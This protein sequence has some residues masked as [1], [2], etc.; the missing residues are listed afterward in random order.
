MTDEEFFL[1]K[2]VPSIFSEDIDENTT[3]GF[4]NQIKSHIG[5]GGGF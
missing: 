3:P 2:P 4:I 5:G 1:K